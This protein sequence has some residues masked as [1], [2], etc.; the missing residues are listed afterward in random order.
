M[1]VISEL[2]F[3]DSYH[4]HKPT[5]IYTLIPPGSLAMSSAVGDHS[6]V[7]RY[8]VGVC[9]CVCVCVCLY[10]YL[11]VCVYVWSLGVKVVYVF[12]Q[13]SVSVKPNRGL[14]EGLRAKEC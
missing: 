12:V 8:Y 11:F 4:T 7:A 5:H 10:V 3:T 6:Y 9:V 13:V 1:Q 2:P 14:T